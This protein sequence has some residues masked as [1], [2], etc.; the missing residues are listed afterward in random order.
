MV[1]LCKWQQFSLQN[2]V[3]PD[4]G[5]IKNDILAEDEDFVPN[6]D[7]IVEADD[8]GS[9]EEELDKVEEEGGDDEDHEAVI[10]ESQI[11]NKLQGVPSALAHAYK[12]RFPNFWRTQ[13]GLM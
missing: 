6:E 8:G 9:S 2:V 3:D 4:Q 11:P 12:K 7:L 10:T 13:Q 5:P 1:N